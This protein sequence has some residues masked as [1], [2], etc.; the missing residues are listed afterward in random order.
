LFFVRH[1]RAVDVAEVA[2]LND[3]QCVARAS[4]RTGACLGFLEQSSVGVSQRGVLFV[5]LF[6]LEL[7]LLNLVLQALEALEALGLSWRNHDGVA[8]GA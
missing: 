4:A 7:Q 3:S 1:G 6:E 8:N 2:G 5:E